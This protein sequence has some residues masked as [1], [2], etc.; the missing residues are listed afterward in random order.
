MLMNALTINSLSK[1]Y[2]STFRE[3]IEAL[4]GVD[5]SVA[6]NEIFGFLGPNGAGKTTTLKIITGLLKPTAGNAFIFGVPISNTHIRQKVGFLPEHPAYYNHLTGFELLDFAGGLFGIPAGERKKRAEAL[7]ERVGLKDVAAIRTNQ[8]SKGMVQRLGIA[9][10]LVNDPELVILDEP[11]SGLDPMGRKEIKDIIIS[12]KDDGKTVFFSTH[13]LADVE[14]ICDRVAILRAGRLLRVG[15]LNELLWDKKRK[16]MIT[17]AFAERNRKPSF[18]DAEETAE[19][20]WSIAVAMDWQTE[21][22]RSML[23]DGARIISVV[24]ES[25]SLEDFFV[26]EIRK[27]EH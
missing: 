16:V 20:Y 4:K 11:L 26:A 5:L 21:A 24:P 13:I 8:Y 9:Q 25:V 18:A 12:L 10:A 7:L 17:V 6:S 27:D 1:V 2:S 15:Q 19:G 23:E 3:R 14:R 22:I